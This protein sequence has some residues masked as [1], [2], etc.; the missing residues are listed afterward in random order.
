MNLI[1]I[2]FVET[3]NGFLFVLSIL[4]KFWIDIHEMR[5]QN[6]EYGMGFG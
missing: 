3:K 1:L 6:I 2:E 4:E 5:K